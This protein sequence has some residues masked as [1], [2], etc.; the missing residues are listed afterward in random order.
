MKCEYCHEE[1]ATIHLTQVIDGEVKKLNLCQK[2]AQQLGIDLNA[3]ISITDM[4]LGLG[5]MKG[6]ATP[7]SPEFDLSCVRCGMTR[8]EF[9][10]RGRFGCPDCY[11]AFMGEI[12]AITKALHHSGQHIGK[13]PARQGTEARISTQIAA[14]TQDLETAVAK[15][16]YE[17]AANLRD[18]INAL[19]ERL[20]QQKEGDADA[21]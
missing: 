3:P 21:D 9:N 11:N 13:I 16:Q 4:L 8:E 15:E 7:T 14:L 12:T 1:D 10:K 18:K 5:A 17:V 20:R 19:K 6:E 2:C